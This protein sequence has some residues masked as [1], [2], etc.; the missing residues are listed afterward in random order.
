MS[1]HE[2]H[3]ID[4][5][6]LRPSKKLFTV[7]AEEDIVRKDEDGKFM[8]RN[9]FYNVPVPDHNM[10]T[11]NEFDQIYTKER[12]YPSWWTISDTWRFLESKQY[13]LEDTKKELE[14]FTFLIKTQNSLGFS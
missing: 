2:F 13:D 3:H 5:S 14:Y 7:K 6:Y 12:T 4:Y 9:T 11:I 10:K 8:Y 1:L